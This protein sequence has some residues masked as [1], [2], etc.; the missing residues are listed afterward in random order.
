M[1]QHLDQANHNLALHDS[2]CSN[3]PD[4]Y[5]D[6]KITLLFY[7]ALHYLKALASMKGIEIGNTHFDIDRNCNPE[8]YNRGITVK[9]PI[10]RNI[11]D[12]YKNLFIYS[13]SARYSGIDDK[14]IFEQLKKADHAYCIKHLEKFKKY[15]KGSGVPL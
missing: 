12:E 9:M 6:W 13:Q 3:F 10:K 5:Y 7:T 8:G 14:A 1:Q 2:L 15:I 11:W 4:Q